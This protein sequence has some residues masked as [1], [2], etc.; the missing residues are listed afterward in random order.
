MDYDLNGQLDAYLTDS[1]V[2]Q[3]LRCSVSKV[4][5]LRRCGTLAYLKRR[6]PLIAVSDLKAYLESIKVRAKSPEPER[7]PLDEEAIRRAKERARKTWADYSKK[8]RSG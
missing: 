4:R 1:E 3:L 6:P 7:P 5:S 2:A 8:P